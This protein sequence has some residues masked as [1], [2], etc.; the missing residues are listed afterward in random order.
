[1]TFKMFIRLQY[2]GRRYVLLFENENMFKCKNIICLYLI[3]ITGKFKNEICYKYRHED[4]F[5]IVK[6]YCVFF[7]FVFH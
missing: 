5:W 2:A 7:H 3:P 4:L 6:T 1:M